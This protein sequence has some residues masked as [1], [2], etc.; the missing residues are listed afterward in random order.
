MARGALTRSAMIGTMPAA[1]GERKEFMGRESIG[2]GPALSWLGRTVTSPE[3]EGDVATRFGPLLGESPSMRRLFGV[4]GRLAESRASILITGE[5]G[6]GKSVIARALHEE[7]PRAAAPFVTV[8]CASLPAPLVEA[9]L[10]GYER[11]AYT[12]A[13]RAH[14]GAFEA[15]R[16]GTVLLDEIGELSLDLQPKLL[17]VLEERRIRRIGSTQPVEIDVRV[18][19][20]TN[21][22]LAPMVEQGHFRRDLYYRLDVVHLCVPPLRERPEDI[23]ALARQFYRS[24]GGPLNAAPTAEVL[25]RFAAHDWPGNVRELRNAVERALLLGDPQLPAASDGPPHEQLAGTASITHPAPEGASGHA[26]PAVPVAQP[27]DARGA[28]PLFAP[29]FHPSISFREAKAQMISAWEGWYL[30]ALLRWS[31]GNVSLAARAAC[32]NR[33]HLQR[34]MQ[35]AGVTARSPPPT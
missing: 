19:A 11:G 14:A 4:L 9:E 26:P 34:V 28:T 31:R 33:T 6:T 20:A 2:F 7:G 23:L 17:Q 30:G 27:S 10:F 32:M 5:T 25:A 1:M 8:D 22:D 13:Y 35:R 24:L 16:G 29:A 18:M 21:R 12:G 3:P 15:A